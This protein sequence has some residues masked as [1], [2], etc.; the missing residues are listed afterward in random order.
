MWVDFERS[1]ALT[2]SDEAESELEECRS[3]L[4][5]RRQR[6]GPAFRAK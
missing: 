3:W 6:L 4:E 5:E 1:S 2:P